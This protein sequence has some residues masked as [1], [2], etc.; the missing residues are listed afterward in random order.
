MF[1][2]HNMLFAFSWCLF[3]AI[4]LALKI[5][6]SDFLAIQ[7][8]YLCGSIV[9]YFHNIHRSIDCLLAKILLSIKNGYNAYLNVIQLEG[10]VAGSQFLDYCRL[11]AGN[12]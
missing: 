9:L 12:N 8:D 5:M 11:I 3:C 10:V 2:L 7:C 1:Y 4:Y 6:I